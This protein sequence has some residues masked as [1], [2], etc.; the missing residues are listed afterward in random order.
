MH[1][2]EVNIHEIRAEKDATVNLFIRVCCGAFMQYL[3]PYYKETHSF[4]HIHH[5]LS[6]CTFVMHIY[7]HKLIER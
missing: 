2:E 1:W 4:M 5:V 6:S 7:Y 3:N